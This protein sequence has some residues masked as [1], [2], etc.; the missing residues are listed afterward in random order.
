MPTPGTSIDGY[1]L[2]RLIGRGGFGAVWLCRSEAVGDFRALKFIPANDADHL[3]KEFHALCQ[4]RAVVGQLRSPSLIPIEHVNFTEAGL[5]YVMPL[6]DGFNAPSPDDPGW[7]PL[8]LA[9][10]IEG[11]RGTSDWFSSAQIRSW[12]T[13]ILQALQLL[14]EASLVHRDVKPDNILFLNGIPCLADIGLLG[15]DSFAITRRGTPGYSAPSWFT[16]AGGHPDMY[17]AATTLYS[18]LTGNP[19]DKIGRAAFRWPP[20]G[21]ASLTTDE[22]TE[23]LRLHCVIRRAID[24]RPAERFIDFTTFARLLIPTP[25]TIDSSPEASPLIE[26][27]THA[28]SS[29]SDSTSGASQ[30]P[31]PNKIHSYL[32]GILLVVLL[33]KFAVSNEFQSRAKQQP[34]PLQPTPLQPKN[35][36]NIAWIS[37]PHSVQHLRIEN[38]KQTADLPEYKSF[39]K[40]KPGSQEPFGTRVT[41]CIDPVTG[42]VWSCVAARIS[43]AETE[44]FDLYSFTHASVAI[45]GLFVTPP[46]WKEILDFLIGIM[47]Q[48]TPEHPSSSGEMVFQGSL[49]KTECIA[50][51]KPDGNTQ[52]IHTFE[53]LAI[54]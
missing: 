24:D 29:T 16:E 20:Q 23:W 22:R 19:P 50:V 34:T 21:E 7:L 12:I 8:T 33:I 2:I 37:L 14:S 40:H 15:A 17:G 41:L 43:T 10:L 46:Q 4:Y 26:P 44:D 38:F 32:P 3:E 1:R 53:V 52:M 18:L 13:P 30:A 49:L 51:R 42:A 39:E 6:A 11:Y 48:T 36:G 27:E 54:E 28:S 25:D 9:A 5:F 35:Q 45:C 31:S 47:K